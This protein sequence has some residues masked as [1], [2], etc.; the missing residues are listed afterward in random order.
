MFIR[1]LLEGEIDSRFLLSTM[2]INIPVYE[3]RDH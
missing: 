3:L 1:D 2:S